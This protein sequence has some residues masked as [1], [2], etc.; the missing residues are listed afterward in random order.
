VA[1]FEPASGSTLSAA[2]GGRSGTEQA[3]SSDQVRIDGRRSSSTRGREKTAETLGFRRGSGMLT[4]AQLDGGEGVGDGGGGSWWLRLG[5]GEGGGAP[6]GGAVEM[7]Q[8]LRLG[9]AMASGSLGPSQ[10]GERG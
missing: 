10:N 4:V 7:L 3:R 1:V 5:D 9:L 2:P 8:T 6:D